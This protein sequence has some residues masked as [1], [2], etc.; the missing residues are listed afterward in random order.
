MP[1]RLSILGAVILG[2]T[3]LWGQQAPQL[4]GYTITVTGGIEGKQEVQY[5]QNGRPMGG[6]LPT[7]PSKN[8]PP[9]TS[10][11]IPNNRATRD[12][13]DIAAQPSAVKGYYT[14]DGRRLPF[15]LE[16]KQG[17][18]KMVDNNVDFNSGLK[19]TTKLSDI[20]QQRFDTKMAPVGRDEVYNRQNIVS[21]ETWHNQYDTIGRKKAEIDLKDTLGADIQP[22]N[23]IEVKSVEFDTSP[24]SRKTATISQLDQRMT[25]ERNSAYNVTPLLPADRAKPKSVDQLSM[26]DINR[27]Q[28][29]RNRSDAPGLPFVRP[30]SDN[31]HTTGSD[32]K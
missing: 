18:A 14:E 12:V 2:L 7:S 32:P 5:D 31:V 25:T 3:S 15:Y 22:K 8:F 20:T 10:G 9:S 6:N 30:G 26:Q 4:T 11:S 23:T 13:V 16:G 21:F 27:Y 1:F 28:F 19:K 29:R 24:W 17:D